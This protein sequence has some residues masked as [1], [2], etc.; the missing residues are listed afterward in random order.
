MSLRSDLIE[1]LNTLIRK[2]QIWRRHEAVVRRY[3]LATGAAD[4][5]L[6]YMEA[7]A[8]LRSAVDRMDLIN[9]LLRDNPE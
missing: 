8:T 1:E 6:E 9:K 5:L 7:F 2:V 4:D 3:F